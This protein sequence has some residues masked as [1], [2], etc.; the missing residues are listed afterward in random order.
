MKPSHL[1]ITVL[2]LCVA[3]LVSLSDWADATEEYDT[4]V[5]TNEDHRGSRY[6]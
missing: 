5:I 1:L 3:L 6:V 4:T 2:F